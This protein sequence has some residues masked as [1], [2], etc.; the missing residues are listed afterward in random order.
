MGC[1]PSS[2]RDWPVHQS[3]FQPS[4]MRLGSMRVTGSMGMTR[5]LALGAGGGGSSA[6]WSST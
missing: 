4:R 6:S 2:G 3:D 5:A 1:R